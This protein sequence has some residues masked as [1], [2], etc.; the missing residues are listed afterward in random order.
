MRAQEIQTAIEAIGA[1]EDPTERAKA[2]TEALGVIHDGNATLATLRRAAISE[3]QAQGMSYRQI[4]P[5]LDL[6][7]SRIGQ[8]MSGE[9]SG[10]GRPGRTPKPKPEAVTSD[11]G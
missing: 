11:E 1:I 6:H 10:V 3:L 8:I 4:A 2:A 9:P 5:A 7:F